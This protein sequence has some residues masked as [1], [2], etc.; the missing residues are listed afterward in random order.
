MTDTWSLQRALMT[1]TWRS[2]FSDGGDVALRV[3]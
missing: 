1:E 3:L 2:D